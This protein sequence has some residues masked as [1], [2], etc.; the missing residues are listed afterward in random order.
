[1]I[2]HNLLPSVNPYTFSFIHCFLKSKTNVYIF[3]VIFLVPDDIN[4]KCNEVKRI[5]GFHGRDKYDF[6][7]VNVKGKKGVTELRN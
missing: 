1:M 3:L 2:E 6:L 7:R 5:S 4:T